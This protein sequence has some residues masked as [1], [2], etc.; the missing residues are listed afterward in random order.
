MKEAKVIHTEWQYQQ[1][2]QPVSPAWHPEH[3][4]DRN[5]TILQVGQGS[6]SSDGRFLG[7]FCLGF[8]RLR[9]LG[10]L[11]HGKL[12]NEMSKL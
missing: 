3:D 5:A 11:K 10:Y 8:G 2:S 9:Q 6:L 12:P 7:Q 1:H 4:A